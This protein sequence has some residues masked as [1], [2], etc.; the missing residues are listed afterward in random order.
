MIDFLFEITNRSTFRAQ[1]M[2]RWYHIREW[3]RQMNS[4]DDFQA[5]DPPGYYD[6]ETDF[7]NDFVEICDQIENFTNILENNQNWVNF[8]NSVRWFIQHPNIM[9]NVNL[10]ITVRNQFNMVYL[11]HYNQYLNWRNDLNQMV[12]GL[13]PTVSRTAISNQNVRRAQRAALDTKFRI[14]NILAILERAR[15]IA[16]QAQHF[17]VMTITIQSL[18]QITIISKMT[19]EARK[20]IQNIVT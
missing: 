3:F 14:D 8:S 7:V 11:N 10:A 12:R 17:D 20:V 9:M 5:E 13:A 19:S 15:L 2:N 16:Q 6:Q 18:T 1:D 4:L